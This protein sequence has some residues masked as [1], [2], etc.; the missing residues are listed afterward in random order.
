MYEGDY[1]WLKNKYRSRIYFLSIFTAPGNLKQRTIY[2]PSRELP[3]EN[4]IEQWVQDFVRNVSCEL[5]QIEWS[6]LCSSAI[7]PCPWNQDESLQIRVPSPFCLKHMVSNSSSPIHAFF[8]RLLSV[9][10]CHDNCTP[11]HIPNRL[12]QWCF[13]IYLP[14]WI[15]SEAVLFWGLQGRNLQPEVRQALPQAPCKM[16]SLGRPPTGDPIPWVP[17]GPLCLRSQPSFPLS[18]ALETLLWP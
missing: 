8:P 12:Q 4:R 13:L 5:G 2:S 15:N 11:G 6:L 18:L 17:C 9:Y 3:D 16:S 1:S 10:S 7:F 14:L